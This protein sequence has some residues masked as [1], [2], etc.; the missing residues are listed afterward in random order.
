MESERGLRL[1]SRDQAQGDLL[2]FGGQFPAGLSGQD[3]DAVVCDQEG[4]FELGR[5]FAVP[6]HRRPTIHVSNQVNSS[7]IIPFIAVNGKGW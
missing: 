3:L 1:R 5:P 7:S 6:R 4:F 2:E